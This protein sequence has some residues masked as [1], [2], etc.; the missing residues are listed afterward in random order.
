MLEVALALHEQEADD[1]LRA[2][3][4]DAILGQVVF[5]VEGDLPQR[6]HCLG[7]RPFLLKASTP[8]PPDEVRAFNL[9]QEG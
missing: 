4:E 2:G 1:R 6:A 5:V 3:E 9:C 7:H 8:T